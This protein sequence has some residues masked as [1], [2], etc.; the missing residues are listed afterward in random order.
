[1]STPVSPDTLAV[2]VVIP[3]YNESASL[4]VLI[5]ELEPVMQGIG[6]PFEVIVVDDGSGDD[7]A[8]VL[9][10]MATERSWLYPFSLPV[11]S[12]QSAALFAG[13]RRARGEV[14]VVM[15]GDLEHDP[16]NIPN[17]LAKLWEGY[18]LVCG[19]R[20]KRN[21]A[22]IR[23]LGSRV[24]NAVRNMVLHDGITDSTWKVFRRE[25]VDYLLP[26]NGMHR[27]FPPIFRNLG[28]RIASVDVTHRTRQHGQS[29]YRTMDR[30]LRGI[31]DLFGVTWLLHR[32]FSRDVYE[33]SR[34]QEE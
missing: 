32:R 25:F 17:L 20:A 1:M 23:R 16:E 14:I 18:D 15:D 31:R 11:N 12:G 5:D 26:F 10:D 21:D 19:R 8:E 4:S 30:L 34:D 2:S 6:K 28:A 3:V 33:V 27:F 9:A 22:W 24:G 13:F 29:H 7:T